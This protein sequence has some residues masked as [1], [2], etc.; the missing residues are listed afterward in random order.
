[1]TWTTA[2]ARTLAE[3]CLHEMGDRWLHVQ[4]VGRSAEELRARRLDVSKALV[5]AAWVHDV[6]YGESVAVTGFHPVDGA[7]WLVDQGAPPAVVALVAHHSGARFE[8]EE[9][10]LVDALTQFP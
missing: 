2:R 3:S 1:M 6:G 10:G 9:R 5:M 8:A 7:S 4:A